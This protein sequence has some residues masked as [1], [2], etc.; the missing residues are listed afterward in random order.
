MKFGLYFRLCLSQLVLAFACVLRAAV[1]EMIHYQGYVTV[2]DVAF[3]GGGQFKF[4]LVD[5]P[6]TTTLWSHDNTSVAGAAPNTFLNITVNQGLYSVLLGDKGVPGMTKAVSPSIFEDNTDVFLRIWFNDGVN[7]FQQLTP[8]T[9]IAAVGF[10]M[11]AAAVVDGGVSSA[12]LSPN[13]TLGGANTAGTLTLK[14][15]G[16]QTRAVLDAGIQTGTASLKLYDVTGAFDTVRLVGA[17]SGGA[18]GQMLLKNGAG[19]TT[20]ELDAQDGSSTSAGG[21]LKLKKDDGKVVASLEADI[22]N[23]N[24]GLLLYDATGTQETLRLTGSHLGTR[25]AFVSLK[26]E[27]GHPT[28]QLFGQETDDGLSASVLN[29]VRNDGKETVSLRSTFGGQDGGSLQIANSSGNNTVEVAGDGG[30]NQG[31]ILLKHGDLANRV[32]IDADG[33]NDSG[34]IKLYDSDGTETIQLLGGQALTKGAAIHLHDA[35]GTTTI[36]LDADD[37]DEA[38]RLELKRGSGARTVR[39]TADLDGDGKGALQLF[40]G[41][42]VTETVRLTG[43]YLGTGGGF[44]HFK[45]KNGNLTVQINGDDNG[46]GKITTQ[47]LQITGGA[48]LSENFE[49]ASPNAE[50]EPGMIVCIDPDRPGELRVSDRPYDATVAGVVSGAGGVKTGMLMGQRGTRADGKY[51]VALTGRVYCGVDA[52]FGAIR[53][54]DLITTSGTPGHGMKATPGR[55]AGA[56]VGKAMTPL[57]A[58]RGL[59]L[60]LISLQ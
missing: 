11:V 32:R 24:S 18:G 16:D 30:E 5:R 44:A 34:E 42:G 6:G 49:I 21:F 15:G 37:P 8:D 2:N 41:D 20:L 59:V 53:P 12:A 60:V 46:E 9:R 4:A 14:S 55:A 47:V 25:G 35:D 26:N 10:A 58:G 36:S 3:S 13:I 39:L 45:D 19:H 1:P 29:L 48:D 56:V 22:D 43:S 57:E 7:G 17:E 23:G 38:G 31:R 40:K 52:T 28:I 33:P 54:G 50:P 27:N 51:P